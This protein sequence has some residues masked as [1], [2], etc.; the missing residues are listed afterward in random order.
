MRIETI[1]YWILE[2]LEGIKKNSK[3]FLIGLG[4]MLIVLCL[5]GSLYILYMNANSFM[6]DIKDDESKVNLYVEGLSEDEVAIITD[7]LY[8]I[9]GI[10]NVEYI[11]QEQAYDIA[12]NEMNIPVEGIERDEGAFDA[13][14][15]LTVDEAKN[16]DMK[17]IKSSIYANTR[18]AEAITDGDGFDEAS[19]VIKIAISVKIITLTLL[20]LFIVMGCFL[21]MNSI[22]L[23]LYARR[24]EISIMKYVGATDT[25][26]RAPFIIE[27][28]II[29]LLAAGLTLFITK[30]LYGGLIDIT[31]GGG[32]STM[33]S[34]MVPIDEVLDSTSLLL[35]LVSTGIGTIGSSMSIS[36]YLD[37]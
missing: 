5:I 11:S 23:A 32:F 31:N 1:G 24:K 18:L 7:H 2:S 36:K 8:K 16:G 28:L 27:G 13:S 22:K 10:S 3:T 33:F 6:G 15:V 14:F 19:R 25:F 12:K 29:A 20:I 21:M 37:V 26:T 35:L 30:I 9:D 4:T 17:L 34:F